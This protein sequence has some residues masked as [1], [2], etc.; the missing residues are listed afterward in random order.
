M[1]AVTYIFSGSRYSPLDIRQRALSC[2]GNT[3]YNPLIRNCEHFATWCVYGKAE[4]DNSTAAM[5]GTTTG[6]GGGA[7]ALIG[8]TIGSII[9]PVA[10]TIAGAIVGGIIGTGAGVVASVVG[11]GIKKVVHAVKDEE[12]DFK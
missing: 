3:N 4:S 11:L 8:G 2:V 5:M 7:G 6:V 10:G 9:V 1:T 12:K